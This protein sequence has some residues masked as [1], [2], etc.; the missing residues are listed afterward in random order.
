MSDPKR[1]LE[2]IA[3]HA[4]KVC[5]MKDWAER[6]AVILTALRE[7]VD[8]ARQEERGALRAELPHLAAKIGQGTYL[9]DR[10]WVTYVTGVFNSWLDARSRAEEPKPEQSEESAYANDIRPADYYEQ[11]INPAEEPKP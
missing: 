1:T 2:E 6:A 7:A 3:E 10:S 11:F 8:A 4:A 9:R 5:A